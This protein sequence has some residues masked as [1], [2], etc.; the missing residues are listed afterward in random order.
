MEAASA[1]ERGHS[2]TPTPNQLTFAGLPVQ[3]A[4]LD[5]KGHGKQ[6][7]VMDADNPLQEGDIIEATVQ[8]VV[9]GQG[10]RAKMDHDGLAIGDREL[11]YPCSP[12]YPFQVGRVIAKAERDQAWEA[13]LAQA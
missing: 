11:V 8:W 1:R 6:S 13:H 9:A 5:V 7:L 2:V 10:A 4:Y 12:I 3:A